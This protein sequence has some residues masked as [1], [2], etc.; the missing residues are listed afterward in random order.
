MLDD[1]VIVIVEEQAGVHELGLKDVTAP[2]GSPEVEK[3]TDC[4]EPDVRAKVAVAL[5]EP[6]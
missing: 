6:P 2:E 1:V 3:A 4:E 5:V